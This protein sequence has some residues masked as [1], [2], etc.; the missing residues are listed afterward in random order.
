VAYAIILFAIAAIAI[1]A[2]LFLVF[3]EV[4]GAIEERLGEYEALPQDLGEWRR[5]DDSPEAAQAARDGL[6]REVRILV[7]P[8]GTFS[9]SKLIRQARYRDLESKQ[10]TRVE[11]DQDLKRRRVKK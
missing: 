5:D 7:T 9:G 6:F 3:R 8:G 11:P 2:Y 1:G 4:P 10:I